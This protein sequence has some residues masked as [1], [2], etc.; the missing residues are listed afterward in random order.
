MKIEDCDI[1]YNINEVLYI[2]T[3]S[4]GL[5]TPEVVECI[6]TGISIPK[7]RKIQPIYHI[8]ST[9]N[10]KGYEDYNTNIKYETSKSK[11]FSTRKMAE[12][13][14]I[15]C[16]KV[17]PEQRKGKTIKFI[18]PNSQKLILYISGEKITFSIERIRF[19]KNLRPLYELH[20]CIRKKEQEK[21]HI[22]NAAIL[23]KMIKL[24]ENEIKD[25]LCGIEDML[26]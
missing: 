4:K 3:N 5:L 7:T 8:V 23:Y 15:S 10:D 1:F 2:I 26:C 21:N 11:V 22:N 16:N 18:S 13:A 20:R 12:K 14:I 17:V 19:D 9:G 25:R 6:V 24:K